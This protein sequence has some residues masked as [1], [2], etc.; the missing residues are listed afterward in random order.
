MP[1]L[2]IDSFASAAHSNMA[3]HLC[4]PF[5]AGAVDTELRVQPDGTIAIPF[6]AREPVLLVAPAQS[7]GDLICSVSAVLDPD[8]AATPLVPELRFAPYTEA[9]AFLPL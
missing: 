3:A 9:G 1:D 2:A 6:S 8:G 5:R 4:G 7:L